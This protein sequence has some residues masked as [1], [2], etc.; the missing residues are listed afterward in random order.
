M[1][2]IAAFTIL[3]MDDHSAVIAPQIV[4]RIFPNVELSL[5]ASRFIGDSL[6]EFGYQQYGVRLRLRAYF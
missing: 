4:Y 3:N 6:D 1:L 5:L 2:D